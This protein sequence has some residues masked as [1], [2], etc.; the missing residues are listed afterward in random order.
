MSSGGVSSSIWESKRQVFL[1]NRLF[2]GDSSR[3]GWKMTGVCEKAGVL[4]KKG[5]FLKN[6]LAFLGEYV[7]SLGEDGCMWEKMSCIWEKAGVCG[8]KGHCDGSQ[9]DLEEWKAVFLR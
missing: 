9:C 4:G 2:L 8:R 7:P 6:K 1:G 3:L 5:R